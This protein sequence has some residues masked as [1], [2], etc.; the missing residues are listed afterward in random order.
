MIYSL[1]FT[2]DQLT[3]IKNLIYKKDSS[4][5]EK[6]PVIP[7]IELRFGTID[8]KFNSNNDPNF[9]YSL[10]EKIEGNKDVISRK[11][12][13]D[14]VYNK[15]SIRKI[16]DKNNIISYQ[17]KD[18]KSTF[19]VQVIKNFK[20]NSLSA[21]RFS[22]ALETPSDKSEYDNTRSAVLQRDRLRHS[23]EFENFVFDLSK[24]VKNDDKNNPT[25][26]I[27]AELKPSFIETLQKEGRVK[28]FKVF[29][30]T[31]KKIFGIYYDNIS[32]LFSVE[33]YAPIK[34]QIDDLYKN[35]KKAVRPKNIY[36]EE[37][38]TGLHKYAVTNKLDGIGYNLFIIVETDDKNNNL[39][40]YL[41][42]KT[43]VWKISQINMNKL[44]EKTKKLIPSLTQTIFD[45]EVFKNGIYVF[46][47]IYSP[48]DTQKLTFFE[49]LDVAQKHMNLINEIRENDDFLKSFTFSVK[50]F[51]MSDDVNE[52]VRNVLN[53]MNSTFGVD[54]L[55]SN[56]GIIFQPSGP[57]SHINQIY[58][59]KFYSKIT[60]DFA[61]K[62]KES[63][64]GFTTYY[65]Q[66]IGKSSTLTT[67]RKPKTGE[68]TEI[69]VDDRESI[70]GIR[71]NKLNN[72]VVEVGMED[73]K[74]KIHRVRFDKNLDDTNF[75][76]TAIKTWEDMTDEL[77]L[78]TVVR[79][80]INGRSR[81]TESLSDVGESSTV[82]QEKVVSDFEEP[83]EIVL[84]NPY[85][86]GK[87][88]PDSDK[89]LYR[90][91]NVSLFSSANP[92]QARY[93][94]E[95]IL[96]YF[97]EDELS[98]MSVL[99]L[100]SCIGGNTW[101]FAKYFQSVYAN[102]LSL[103]HLN[104]LKNNMYSMGIKNI[105]YL[106][107]NAVDIVKKDL[108]ADVVFADPPWGGIDYLNVPKVGYSKNGVFHDI[109]KFIAQHS[110]I[111]KKM[112]ILRLPK[113][114][115]FDEK[116]FLE[117][118]SG[119]DDKQ[120]QFKYFT[121][122]SFYDSK[123]VTVYNT[124]VI[125]KTPQIKNI[126]YE[127]IQRVE[128]KFIKYDKMSQEQQF[129]LNE[130]FSK[131]ETLLG[132]SL[133]DVSE[134]SPPPQDEEVIYDIDEVLLKK[135]PSGVQGQKMVG[136]TKNVLGAE[137]AQLL[138]NFIFY[139]SLA[140]GNKQRYFNLNQN[141]SMLDATSF[142]G[143]TTIVLEKTF[144]N[145]RALVNTEGEMQVLKHNLK[146]YGLENVEVIKD[147]DYGKQI[148]DIIYVDLVLRYIP[149]RIVKSLKSNCKLLVLRVPSNT[150]KQYIDENFEPSEFMESE[151]V[152]G[153][154]FISIFTLAPEPMNIYNNVRRVTITRN[155][156][157]IFRKQYNDVKKNL[158]AE[159][160]KHR[161]VLDI[162]FGQGGDI[163][164]YMRSDVRK[165]F[166]VEP[167]KD[168]I[169]EFNNRLNDV[170]GKW[171]KENLLLLNTEGQNSQE[172]T[173]F[174]KTNN[175]K[176]VDTVNM[177]F[178]LSFF[179]KNEES[180]KA[181]AKTIGNTLKV[182]GH[183]V[184][185]F[186]D[187]KKIEHV[188]TY[189]K[190]LITPCYEIL[191]VNV[192]LDKH[193]NQEII[194]NMRDSK[195]AQTQTEYL[196]Y[197]EEL[198]KE[199]LKYDIYLEK[200][201]SSDEV[202]NYS[203]LNSQE[204]Y[205]ATF[206]SFFVFK[207]GYKNIVSVPTMSSATI[208]G[209][210][211]VR[212]PIIPDGNCFFYSV[213]RSLD[214]ELYT[215]QYTRSFREHLEANYSIEDFESSQQTCVIL[216]QEK[217]VELSEKSDLVDCYG[218][219]Y[220]TKSR[221]EIVKMFNSIFTKYSYSEN[222]E[223]YMNLVVNELTKRGLNKSISEEFV[224]GVHYF[225]YMTRSR[226]LGNFGEWA[227]SWMIPYVEKQLNI[228]IHVL[229]NSTGRLIRMSDEPLRDNG[230]INVLLF[231]S[232]NLHFEP[233]CKEEKGDYITTYN[234]DEIKSFL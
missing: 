66:V 149:T 174:I 213:L 100:S 35:I 234:F 197:L 96:S 9:F 231:N 180:L 227:E 60:I 57:Y 20:S 13:S 204:R 154:R 8:H 179:F 71:G 76:T 78:P 75:I 42:N 29:G 190:N 178:S 91:S 81:L 186:M 177:F 126:R 211:L 220:K 55:K 101:I 97:T 195:T 26:E 217:M 70:N 79:L 59:W 199:L 10:I 31:I 175:K 40:F 229:S 170:S 151:D 176:M 116:I 157:E 192:N 108:Q 65:C 83:F 94:M 146:L 182:D 183:F 68:L 163:H 216:L 21:I 202:I 6:N 105:T 41:K 223:E 196:V 72:F 158:I 112:I 120:E 135:F 214:S 34:K 127:P 2:Q 7:E 145:I 46:D 110:W 212:L 125:T 164:K 141:S 172:I 138:S 159:Y 24:V 200:E 87:Y 56:D 103:I 124:I 106:N 5:S 215:E 90:F 67:F 150:T 130:N 48:E 92:S 36:R 51:F 27:E 122:V 82:F 114:Y 17:K 32:S 93:T 162:G 61:F 86:A 119:D 147:F 129:E 28:T 208:N 173:D 18:K 123:N 161:V 185:G 207:R 134:K 11:I 99:D 16:I 44:N 109:T 188:L 33:A 160:S 54:V 228:N 53:E 12:T 113:N 4:S 218:S 133:K 142:I 165:V 95:I 205:L 225:N 152:G 37:A 98:K 219:L 206:Y 230:K 89:N 144:K 193:F 210:N 136:D 224:M 131:L 169:K 117:N 107:E 156:M 198:E 143:V 201:I 77:T 222:L 139:N 132:I 118:L 30:E 232:N 140:Y 69:T 73:N 14:T 43:N 1:S 85:D 221:G 58:K 191:N 19:D 15:D 45:T 47:I 121:T 187:G 148:A 128:Y 63:K 209:D 52:D 84:R 80:L 39:C 166:A 22:S 137:G 111:A 171:V 62:L 226:V 203:V 155:C 88:F 184:G 181:L 50:K 153:Y 25:Y 74:L 49:R 194:F 102:E 167:N 38:E 189:E 233:L 104:L 23:Y 168:F 3:G 64:N 115:V